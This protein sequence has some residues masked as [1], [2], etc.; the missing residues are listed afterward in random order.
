MV[1]I[2]SIVLGPSGFITHVIRYIAY[3]GLFGTGKCRFIQ[4]LYLGRAPRTKKTLP[5][6]REKCRVTRHSRVFRGLTGS[7][8]TPGF[9]GVTKIYCKLEMIDHDKIIRVRPMIYSQEDIKDFKIKLN[10]L[11][12]MKLIK[13]SKS[14]YSSPAFMVRKHN[15]IK[16]GKSRMMINYKE[17]NKNTKFYGYYI[18][19][20]EILINLAR[21][22]NYYNKFDCKS[23]F[24]QIQID[25]DSLPITALSTPRGHYEWM[26]MPLGLKNAPQVFQRKIDKIFVDYF[27]LYNS[28]H[29]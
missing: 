13:E 2:L 27:G 3:I 10:K 29:R 12:Q 23:G 26:V 1:C 24:W 15:E 17:V 9:W 5:D 25:N 11:M 22:K 28:I 14:P 20:K 4:V 8:R 7:Q 21:G 18:P 19:N 6:F 16:R